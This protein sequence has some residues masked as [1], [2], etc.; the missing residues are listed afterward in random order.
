MEQKKIH[1]QGPHLPNVVAGV[2]KWH[3]V[4]YE[5]LER[6]VFTS[7]DAGIATFDH[8]D[9]YGNYT[10]EEVFGNVIRKNQHLKQKI[11]IVTKCGIKLLSDKKDHRIKHYDTSKAHILNSVDT[12]LKNIGVESI[13]VLLIH[14]PNPLL[15]P[16]E[17]ADAFESL[18][19]Q[20]KVKY[21]GVSNF[22]ANQFEMLQQFLS[23][24]LVTNQIEISLFRNEFMF[25]G[26]LDT[27]IK[28][29]V[30][31]MAWSPLGGGKHFETEAMQKVTE[32]AAQRQSTAAQL[33][34][35]WLLKHPAGIVPIL[36][37]TKPERIVEA[38][39]AI[40]IDLDTQTWFEM[41]KWVRGK[42]VA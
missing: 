20:G 27:L 38:A 21:F 10:C 32:L 17:V 39:Q 12:S 30:S 2:W 5:T 4:P 42:D 26:Q 13:D 19:S 3:T 7:I 9:I 37:T 24:P 36:G 25:D 15:N 35:A 40:E 1:P 11:Q 14:R 16:E 29:R 41:L 28:H 33:L 22:T 8:A 6:L 18:R 23:F 34:L 31:P